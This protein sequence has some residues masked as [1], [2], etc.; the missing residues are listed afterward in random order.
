[1]IFLKKI[2]KIIFLLFVIWNPFL[3]YSEDEVTVSKLRISSIQG[4]LRVIIDADQSPAYEVFSLKN[5]NRLVVDLA[6]TNFSED[7]SFPATKGFIKGIRFGSFNNDVSRIVFDLNS[8]V[9]KI[10]SRVRKP[11][12]GSKRTLNIDIENYINIR[13]L[14]EKNKKLEKK[15]IKNFKKKYSRN[16]KLTIVID[17]GHGGKDPGTSYQSLISEKEIVLNFSSILKKKLEKVGYRVYLTRSADNFIKLKERVEFAKR[18]GADLFISVHADASKYSSTRG[19]SVYTLSKKGL[20]REAEKVA[21]LEN[22]LSVFSKKGLKGI[23]LRDARN[24]KDQYYID[25]AFDRAK[26]SSTEFADILVNKVEERSELL[27]RPHRYAGFAVL[28]SP[29]YPSVLVEL[30]FITNDNDRNNFGNRNWQ[31]SVAT[32]FVE[33]INQNFQ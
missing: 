8:S 22:S 23:N 15:Q 5:P 6:K 7:F 20:D 10:K 28:K 33:A 21:K 24:I 12:S 27:T 2:S 14:N 18:K 29:N 31:S 19:F 17:P 16:K 4:G 13:T 32:K 9:K 1:M 25:L 3:L 11:S 30:G 26:N